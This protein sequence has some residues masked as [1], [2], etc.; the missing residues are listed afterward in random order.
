MVALSM[1]VNETKLH[2]TWRL[3]MCV[4]KKDWEK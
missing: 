4:F 2:D 1:L 3:K